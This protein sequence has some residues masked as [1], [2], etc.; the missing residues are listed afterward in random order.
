M[1]AL[2][3]ALFSLLALY[4][5]DF[6]KIFQSKINATDFSIGGALL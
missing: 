6:Q 4:L 1:H 3:K 5:L 2:Q